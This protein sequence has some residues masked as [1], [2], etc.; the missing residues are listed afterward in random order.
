V[1][2]IGDVLWEKIVSETASGV[3]RG[4]DE[5]MGRETVGRSLRGIG[6]IGGARRVTGVAVRRAFSGAAIGCA[7][8]G[9][10]GGGDREV[11]LLAGLFPGVQFLQERNAPLTSGPRA[12]A[13]CKLAGDRWVLPV[14]KRPDLSKADSKTEAD[15]VIWIHVLK[16]P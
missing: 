6:R 13:V 14:E 1:G 11:D 4:L 10:V 16:S 2:R 5:S 12:Q 15:L 3:S 7:K 8:R 9:V